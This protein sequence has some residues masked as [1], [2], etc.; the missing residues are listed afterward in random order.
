MAE[1]TAGGSSLAH[2]TDGRLLLAAV[3]GL[4]LVEALPGVLP[5]PVT[6]PR[7]LL[8]TGALALVA[9]ASLRGTLPWFALPG[10]VPPF[11]VFCYTSLVLPWNQLSFVLAQVLF[12]VALA[13][14]VIG[15][16]V[17][18]LLFGGVT[19]TT[20]FLRTVAAVHDALVALAC[21]AV[22]GAVARSYL[23]TEGATTA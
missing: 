3:V 21:L 9:V 1:P 14:P 16:R 18:V 15:D 11:L 4:V 12:E 2:S 10:A 13:V 22:V 19:L 6:A 23:R 8:A 5:V 20:T 17:V 7:L